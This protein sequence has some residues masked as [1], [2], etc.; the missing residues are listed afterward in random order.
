M[1]EM[2]DAKY[3]HRQL[4]DTADAVH[5]ENKLK[6]FSISSLTSV[7]GYLLLQRSRRSACDMLLFGNYP[8]YLSLFSQETREGYNISSSTTLAGKEKKLATLFLQS[9][10]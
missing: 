4:A 6:T 7:T 3:L 2:V 10:R 5:L 1:L 9:P 8:A